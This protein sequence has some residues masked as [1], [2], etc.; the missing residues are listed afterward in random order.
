M[1]DFLT[2]GSFCAETRGWEWGLV[3]CSNT[4]RFDI[5][6][7]DSRFS[8]VAVLLLLS[9]WHPISPSSFASVL[10]LVLAQSKD[11]CKT[12]KLLNKIWPHDTK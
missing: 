8:A 7:Q 1:A 6:L 4:T 5:Q 10:Q 2:G 3:I 9:L 12:L 11:S